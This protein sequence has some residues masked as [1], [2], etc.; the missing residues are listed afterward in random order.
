M[1]PLRV[2]LVRHG[3]SYNNALL[4]LPGMTPAK[5]QETRQA[6]PDLSELGDRQAKALGSFLSREG[7]MPIGSLYVSPVKRALQSIQPAAESLGLRAQVWTDCFEFGGIYHESG[8]SDRG[9]SREEM[10]RQFPFADVPDDV[11]DKGWYKLDG[12]ESTS[13]LLERVNG[14]AKRLQ[15]MAQQA[16]T[17]RQKGALLL[18]S[19]HDT[20]DFLLQALIHG[21]SQRKTRGAFLHENTAM[22]CLDIYPDGRVQ[23][24]YLNRVDHYF[25]AGLS[26]RL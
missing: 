22:S 8:T 3:E 26:S 6:D 20:M 24:V 7:A 17:E 14:M 16:E 10:R 9:L 5:W 25:A 4:D 11:T 18:L 15:S 2:L 21:E 1:A 23:V 19:H 13:Q 12:K